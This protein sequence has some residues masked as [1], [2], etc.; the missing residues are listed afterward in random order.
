[1]SSKSL[2]EEA[3]ELFSGGVNSPV[4]A[5]VKPYP[6]YVEGAYGAY[7]KTVDGKNVI[8]YVMAYGPLILGHRNKEVMRKVRE[9]IEKGWIFGTPTI[10]ELELAKKVT[11]Y[12]HT[13][14]VRF[15]NS[16]TEAAMTAIRLARGFTKRSKIVKFEGCYHG[17]SDALLFKAGSAATHYG[18]ATSA[19]IPEGLST[20]TYVLPFNDVDAI[21][22]LMS[23]EGDEIAAIIVEPVVANSGLILPDLGFLKALRELTEKHS[24][25][26]VFDEVV[27]GFRLSLG[28]AQEF[29]GIRPD[30]TTLG[31]IIGGGFPI[32]CV[33]SKREIM[34]FLAP[35]GPVFNAGT[36]NA[37]PIS[38]VAGLA[39]INVLER[40]EVYDVANSAAKKI[41]K[42]LNEMV[43]DLKIDA[44]VNSIASMLQIFFT[45][46]LVRNY[47]DAQR[48]DKDRYM[49]LHEKLLKLDV[50]IPPSQFET[51]FTSSSHTSDI[52]EL[53]IL[54]IEDA[55]KEVKNEG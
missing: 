15:L 51:W 26:L 32:G 35:I 22:R 18:V 1:M 40:N 46:G 9:Q 6:F 14:M 4:R 48:S 39:T 34:E 28:G 19:G 30:I 44:V 7:L 55:L 17:A 43:E 5:A 11:K 52:V 2:Y 13:D 54:K 24:A 29:F 49:R 27:T 8:D 16:G 10:L 23:K 38:M 21:E 37:H 33:T 53:T 42:R 45:K 47:S 20:Q 50:F 12:Y 25:L 36:F 3:K 31:K 41:S